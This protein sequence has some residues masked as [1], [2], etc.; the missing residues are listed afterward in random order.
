MKT[1]IR[2]Y[3]IDVRKITPKSPL[4]TQLLNSAPDKMFMDEAERQG[5]VMTLDKFVSDYNRDE[6][7]SRFYIR[8]IEVTSKMIASETE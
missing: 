4:Y 3:G 8:A 6:L 2:I 7:D 1:E 5:I